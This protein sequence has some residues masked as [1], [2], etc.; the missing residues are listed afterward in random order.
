MYSSVSTVPKPS[1]EW[2]ERM[3]RYIMSSFCWLTRI[4]G[5]ELCKEKSKFPRYNTR[6]WEKRDTKQNIPRSIS[7]SQLQYISCNISENWLPSRQCVTGSVFMQSDSDYS[8]H[9]T[10]S[11]CK[12][13]KLDFYV[14]LV[15]GSNEWNHSL[16]SFTRY[17]WVY[18]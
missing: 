12:A 14:S 16:W 10:Y 13:S 3:Q 4:S 8:W 5:P 2:L 18:H 17:D 6:C 9:N 7:F 11:L 15:R 1:I